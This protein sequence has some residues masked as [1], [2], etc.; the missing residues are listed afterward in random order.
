MTITITCDRC[1]NKHTMST[2]EIK[3][4]QL[5]DNLEVGGFRYSSSDTKIKD[6]RL[7]EITI[8]CEECR[9]YLCLGMD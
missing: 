8:Q 2:K 6:G 9:D 1:G 7:E 3:Y 4:L 5:R